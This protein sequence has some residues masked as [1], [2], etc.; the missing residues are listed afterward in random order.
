MQKEKSRL[1]LN[2]EQLR[3]LNLFCIDLLKSSTA[4]VIGFY[5]IW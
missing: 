2:Q 1:K 5:V 4:S 3:G